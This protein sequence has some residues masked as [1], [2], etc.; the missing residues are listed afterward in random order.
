M[1]SFFKRLMDSLFGPSLT[2]RSTVGK[3]VW[4]S[5]NLFK[6]WP[7]ENFEETTDSPTFGVCP[8]C[9]EIELRAFP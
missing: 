8:I 3:S 1:K 6:Y 7:T 4:H 2:Y 9:V 5:S